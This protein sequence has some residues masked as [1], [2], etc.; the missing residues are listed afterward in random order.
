MDN[1]FTP[2]ATP[3]RSVIAD[4]IEE[5]TMIATFSAG[6]IRKLLFAAAAVMLVI[7]D[8]P[9]AFAD[10]LILQGSTTFNRRVI[11][12]HEGEIEAKSGQELT[13]IPNRTMLGII[14]LMEGRAHMAMVSAS[15]ESEVGKLRKAM[16]GLDYDRL[17]AFEIASTRVAF[18]VHPS[19]PV[20]KATITQIK[21]VL[22][23]EIT[24]WGALG[25]KPGPIRMVIVGGGGGVVTTVESE[26]LDGKPVHG[27]NALYVRTALQLIQVVEQTPNA[28]GFAQLSLARQKGL[29]ELVTDK[30][31]EQ[32]L[33]LI[34]LGEP[35]PAM[36]AVIDAARRAV[37]K[38]M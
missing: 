32:T 10:P 29:P 37:E 2:Y 35:T 3:A 30:P 11:E 27:P 5:R 26:L 16:P 28:M 21:Q 31:V 6:R 24:D 12:P 23:G 19:N 38:T 18:V 15:L 20:R 22:T 17:K 13:V 25:G 34:T 8:I 1:S 36:K 4:L 33:S 7:A 9:H 14:A